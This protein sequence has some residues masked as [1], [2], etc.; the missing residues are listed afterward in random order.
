MGKGKKIIMSII[1]LFVVAIVGLFGSEIVLKE[2]KI[3]RNIATATDAASEEVCTTE[4]DYADLFKN[5]YDDKIEEII[6]GMTL[7]EKVGQLFFIKN[8]SRFQKDILDTYPVGG[9]ILFA[10]DFRGKTPERLKEEL[11]GFQENSKYPLFFGVDEEGGTVIRLSSNSMLAEHRFEAPRDIFN[12]GGFDAIYEDAREKS[13]LLLSYGINVNFAP[14]CDVS[15][16]KRDFIYKRSFGADA[17]ETSQYVSNVVT[18]MKE[19][20]IGSVLKHF[21]GYGSNGDTHSDIIYDKRDYNTFETVDFKPFLAGIAAGSECILINHNIVECMDSKQPASI[22][23]YVHE[24]LRSE[25]GFDGVIITDDLMMG[26]VSKY[27]SDR[28]SAVL[29]IKAGNDMVLSTDYELQYN[30]LL[31]AVKE[32]EI[33]E[34]RIEE[35]VKRV[36]RWKFSIGLM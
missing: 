16:D 32:G 1:M 31:A 30:S 21:P 25:L 19:E 15:T 9:I 26:G 24:L 11:E 27:V 34:E 13:R 2:G 35:S 29:A 4:S 36:L 33:S 8:D 22:S 5:E 20:G 23:P 18:A 14:V 17:E 10:S 12:K 7:E 28:E 3:I 6:S